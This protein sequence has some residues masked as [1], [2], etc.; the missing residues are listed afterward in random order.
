[1]ATVA[2]FVVGV[3]VGFAAGVYWFWTYTKPPR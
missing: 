3:V 1:L 2:S